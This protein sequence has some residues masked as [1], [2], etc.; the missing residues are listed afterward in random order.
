MDTNKER[1]I[2]IKTFNFL[3]IIVS[4]VLYVI[5]LY[6][7]FSMSGKY[8][9][10]IDTMQKYQTCEEDADLLDEASAYL[11]EQARLYVMNLNP[12]Y[13]DAYFAELQD[14]CR[15]EQAM[16][17]LQDYHLRDEIYAALQNAF[18]CSNR[19]AERE[20]Y[21]MELA[22]AS[23]EYDMSAFLE[24]FPELVLDEADA[25]L[26]PEEMQE[27]ARGLLFDAEYLAAKAEIQSYISEALSPILEE[28]QQESHGYGEGLKHAILQERIALGVLFLSDA[29]MFIFIM[30]LI[31]RPLKIF[32][33]RIQEEKQLDV[34]G[35]REFQYLANT[36]NQMYF[37]NIAYREM[38]ER[39]AERDALTGIMNRGAFDQTAGL[40]Q[41]KEQ[42]I[43]LLVVDIDNFKLINDTYG[44]K[45][46]DQILQKVARLLHGSFRSS[47]SVARFGG[48]E[49]AVIM[50]EMTKECHQIIRK[51]VEGMNTILQHP[52]DGLP[53]VSLSI[54]IAY[55]DGYSQKLFEEADAALY[56][57]KRNGRCGCALY[58]GA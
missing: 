31:G 50:S 48:D 3:T 23:V 33:Q 26:A 18:E 34:I 15:R 17:A 52:D 49:F 19:L 10:L 2:R 47:D 20:I 54:G 11:T 41:G 13:M 30:L 27:K 5:L 46:G 56:E 38:L 51:K 7:T 1:G 40:L 58:E 21:A 35:G 4:A 32:V 55:G 16:E 12:E 57:V 36:Y 37:Q 45:T 44:H 42:P 9:N 14:E 22:A 24:E 43:A 29:L 25:S 39:K 8:Q 53:P 28:T 6:E